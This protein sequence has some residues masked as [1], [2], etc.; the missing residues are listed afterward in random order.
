MHESGAM[1][2]IIMHCIFVGPAGVGKSSLLRRLLRMKLDP[3]RTS[4]Q[5]AEK[6]VRV[7]IKNISKT[8]AQVSGLDWQKIADPIS[9]ASGLIGLLSTNQEKAMKDESHS[10]VES[11]EPEQTRDITEPKSVSEQPQQSQSQFRKAIEFLRDVLKKK[12]VSGLQ[13]HVRP[14]TL[15]LTD[16]GGQPEFQELLP[17][18][19]VGPCVFF[20]VFPL[21]KDLKKKYEVEYVRPHEEKCMREYL[22]SLTIQE[23]IMRSF[24]SIAYTK[25]KDIHGKEVKP[26]VLL[27][28]T[29]KDNVPEKDRQRRLKELQDMVEE[30]D[31]Y[32]QGMIVD[33]YETQMVFTINNL[34]DDE[35]EKDARKYVMLFRYL[36]MLMTLRCTLPLH[37]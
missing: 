17:A 23:D 14:L 24:A 22:S 19:V 25:Y 8:A 12:G 29:F 33:A 6:S 30:T 10:M 18:L 1:D 11:D 5:A 31:A 4:T 36:P 32:R 27:V 2:Q 20:V 21:D 26:R 37:G 13:Q 7:E 28:A 3:K 9:Q 34:S 16:S 15:Y 35:S